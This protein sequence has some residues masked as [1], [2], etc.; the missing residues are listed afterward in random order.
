VR[1]EK[2]C[3]EFHGYRVERRKLMNGGD[4][5]GVNKRAPGNGSRRASKG[6]VFP[7][8]FQEFDVVEF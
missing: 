3:R 1:G 2:G 8:P 4:L 5:V 6:V 7:R